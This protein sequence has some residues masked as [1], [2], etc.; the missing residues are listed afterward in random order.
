[1]TTNL[2]AYEL[3][4]R[5]R[6]LLF[7]RGRF[8]SDAIP[9]FERALTYDPRYA[10]ALALLSDGYRAQALFGGAPSDDMM[11]RAKAAAERALAIEPELPEALATLAD[12]EALYHEDVAR[13][14]AL[15]KRALVADPRHVRSHCE[16]ALFMHCLGEWTAEHGVDMVRPIVSD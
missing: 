3:F 2:E 15:W 5:G 12:V 8:V 1:G 10:H 14:D 9:C 11:P 7:K 4:L 13:A 6:V 16:R